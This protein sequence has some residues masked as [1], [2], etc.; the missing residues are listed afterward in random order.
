M[1]HTEL[2]TISM[3]FYVEEKGKPR[4]VYT[5]EGDMPQE[6]QDQ[7]QAIVGNGLAKIS[8]GIP[9]DRKT[10]GNGAG[11]HVSISLTCNQDNATINAAYAL[12]ASAVMHYVK[13]NLGSA[14]QE[15]NTIIAQ[16]PRPQ[17]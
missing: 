14:L 9:M 12:A 11:A 15:F 5:Y 13:Q 8:L 17:D 10:F 2:P 6:I 4:I 3:E 16:L 7:F 1:A